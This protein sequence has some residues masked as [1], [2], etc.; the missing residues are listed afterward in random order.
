MDVMGF[1]YREAEAIVNPLGRFIDQARAYLKTIIFTRQI[2]D[3]HLRSPVLQAH[4]GR[5]PLS[6]PHD[7][8]LDEFYLLKPEENDI[9]LPKH[10]YSAFIGTPLDG[11][12]RGRGIQTLIVTGLAANVCVESTAR[13][14]FMMEYHIVVPS[15]LTA[16]VSKEAKD[17]TLFNIDRFFGEVVDSGRILETWSGMPG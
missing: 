1:N 15:D 13:D 5:S 16:G 12:L 11:L 3:P 17:M 14:G 4:F 6:R 8:T 7:P 9:V 2:R 10:R